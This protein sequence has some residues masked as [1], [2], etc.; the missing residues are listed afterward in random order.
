[1][2]AGSLLFLL[3]VFLPERASFQK[4][5]P[6]VLDAAFWWPIFLISL[7]V[8]L[9]FSVDRLVTLDVFTLYLVY[10]GLFFTARKINI[11]SRELEAVTKSLLAASLALS[12]IGISQY[13]TADITRVGSLFYWAN[14]YAGWLLFSLPLCFFFL[15]TVR[16]QGP[17]LIFGLITSILGAAL[18][19]TESRAA[20]ISLLLVLPVTFF[21]MRGNAWRQ[22]LTR[23]LAACI[24]IFLVASW[25]FSVKVGYMS[26][27]FLTKYSVGESATDLG[28]AGR[29]A[30]WQ[31]AW[32]MF[33]A[34]PLFGW[35]AGTYGVVYPPFQQGVLLYA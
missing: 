5:L 28:V 9:W 17:I 3:F 22:T 29:A 21:A 18:I 19:L 25:L 24:G 33:R 4:L 30:Y 7:A 34:R 11:T 14:A 8:S 27:P 31:G 26:L 16:R 6:R 20:Y 13:L 35:G 23:T 32:D 12:F 1:M 2:L 15:F 10:A